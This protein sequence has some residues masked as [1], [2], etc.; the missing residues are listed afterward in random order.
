MDRLIIVGA[1]GLGR[2]TLDIAEAINDPDR[3]FEHDGT[4]VDEI[5]RL[6]S[7][8]EDGHGL[9]AQRRRKEGGDDGGVGVAGCLQGP[10]HVEEA[11]SEDRELVAVRVS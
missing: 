5:T 3:V 6:S 11:Q 10:E 4:D 1:G 7:I 2:Q 8:S 9:I